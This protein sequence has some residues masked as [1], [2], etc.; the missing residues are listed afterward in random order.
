[1]NMTSIQ[2]LLALLYTLCVI[3]IWRQPE[4]KEALTFKVTSWVF[5]SFKQVQC[6]FISYNQFIIQLDMQ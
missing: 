1:M 5:I 2:I 3:I 4:S 6:L